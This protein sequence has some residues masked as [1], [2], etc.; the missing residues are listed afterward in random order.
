MHLALSGSG[1][2]QG[3]ESAAHNDVEYEETMALA[4]NTQDVVMPDC[5]GI[6]TEAPR[7]LRRM[8]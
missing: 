1:P 5:A 8:N 7:V 6:R 3:D 2:A 4:L